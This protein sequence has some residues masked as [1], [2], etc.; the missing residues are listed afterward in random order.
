MGFVSDSDEDDFEDD[1]GLRGAYAVVHSLPDRPVVACT[2]FTEDNSPLAHRQW[3]LRPDGVHISCTCTRDG[4]P[5]K[6]RANADG[7]TEIA[8][9]PSEDCSETI[10]PEPIETIHEQLTG[11]I[12]AFADDW[13]TRPIRF[14]FKEGSKETPTRSLKLTG[15]WLDEDAL[16]LAAATWYI[17][18]GERIIDQIEETAGDLESVRLK[19]PADDS[20]RRTFP[21]QLERP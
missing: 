4:R 20:I 1:G 8:Q 11:E 17:S 2:I 16:D 10:A 6:V 19:F 21:G 13:G 12:E 7:T 5:L 18:E 14:L 15:L 3:I 9:Q